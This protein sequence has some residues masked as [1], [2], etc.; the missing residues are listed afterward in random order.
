MANA[1]RTVQP[2]KKLIPAVYVP[3]RRGLAEAVPFI[4]TFPLFTEISTSR[5]SQTHA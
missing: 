5:S 2:E 3:R 4:Y 1:A